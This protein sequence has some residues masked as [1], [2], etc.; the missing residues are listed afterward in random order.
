M[1]G[2]KRYKMDLLRIK[3]RQCLPFIEFHELEK[4]RPNSTL[5]GNSDDAPEQAHLAPL[6]GHGENLYGKISSAWGKQREITTSGL[7]VNL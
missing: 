4:G 2:R 3:P 6:L 7:N 5:R 1:M